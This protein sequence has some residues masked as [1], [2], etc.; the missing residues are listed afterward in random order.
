MKIFAALG[1]DIGQ[2]VVW[3]KKTGL[4]QRCVVK[5]TNPTKKCIVFCEALQ[6]ETNFLKNYNQ[7][8]R[9]NIT[10]PE[11]SI[12]M[13]AW[14]RARLGGLE[15]QA[16]YPLEVT[17]ADTYWGKLRACLAHPQIV[18]RVA[19]WLGLLS[20]ALGGVGVVLG[21]ISICTKV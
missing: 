16:D 14:Y 7:I 4:P 15:T 21:V 3:L 2:G 17:G 11:S 5:I 13:S 10:S 9:L 12:V 18:V 8:P 1:D 19:A 20:V 6:F